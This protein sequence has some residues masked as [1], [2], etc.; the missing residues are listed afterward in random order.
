MKKWINQLSLWCFGGVWYLL[1]ETYVWEWRAH[2]EEFVTTK[3]ARRGRAV[4]AVCLFHAG[5]CQPAQPP[6]VDV[7]L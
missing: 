7:N 3:A 1:T 2:R 5:L 6:R 4:I